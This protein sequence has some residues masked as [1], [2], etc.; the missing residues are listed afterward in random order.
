MSDTM[1]QN[2]THNNVH[3]IEWE[4]LI[5]TLA[6]LTLK[7]IPDPSDENMAEII[8]LMKY[9]ANVYSW[10]TVM[11]ARCSVEATAMRAAGMDKVEVD[12]MTR[13]KDAI[14][15]ISRGVRYKQEACSRLLTGK[16][17]SDEVGHWDTP[18]VPQRENKVKN[19]NT[20]RAGRTQELP[21]DE[22]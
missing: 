11:Y 10:L 13:R 17:A 4:D 7:E 1:P 8:S 20:R 2:I 5:Q 16:M 19:W 14:Y 22:L 9:F 18:N 6:D 3:L 21:W 15:E 12:L